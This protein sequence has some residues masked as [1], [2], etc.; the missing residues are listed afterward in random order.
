[1]V[2]PRDRDLLKICHDFVVLCLNQNPAFGP[3][4]VRKFTSL[5]LEKSLEVSTFEREVGL[6]N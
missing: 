5:F 1:M 2:S 4:Q 3:A 6:L